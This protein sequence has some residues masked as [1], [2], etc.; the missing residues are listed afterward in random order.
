MAIHAECPSCGHTGRA[1]D[2]A[3]GKN[4]KCPK[5]GVKFVLGAFARDE[6]N[7]KVQALLEQANGT[8]EHERIKARRELVEFI[9]DPV[10]VDIFVGDIAAYL[11][12]GKSAKERDELIEFSDVAGA[13][14]KVSAVY[15]VQDATEA[16][17]TSS[18]KRVPELL[19]RAARDGSMHVRDA[20]LKA[21]KS[22]KDNHPVL[23]NLAQEVFERFK[24]Y[25][26]ANLPTLFE[27]RCSVGVM[28]TIQF[29]NLEIAAG[30]WAYETLARTVLESN[31][32]AK[33]ISSIQ[34]LEIVAAAQTLADAGHGAAIAEKMADWA[35]THFPS[36][37]AIN[38]ESNE[39]LRKCG[40]A[41]MGAVNRQVE[42]WLNCGS[43]AYDAER[44]ALMQALATL[45]AIGPRNEKAKQLVQRCCSFQYSNRETE[46]AVRDFGERMSKQ[47]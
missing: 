17:A 36:Y 37:I 20:A 15:R 12:D 21:L 26:E 23:K 29:L 3:A 32:R 5:C 38:R 43:Y 4:I 44:N 9:S 8:V 22:I 34:W 18:D 46:K 6:S 31:P 27:S 24:K 13:I 1:P 16:L 11:N 40:V 45:E 25:F 35:Q 28:R 41:A 14:P 19:E 42:Y 7:P 2:N 30:S 39:I 10:V 33:S 47:I